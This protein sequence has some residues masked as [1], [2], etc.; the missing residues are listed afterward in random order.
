MDSMMRPLFG[1]R[2]SATTTRKKGRL[3]APIRRNLILT[4]MIGFLYYNE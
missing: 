3:R 2:E 4:A 1:L